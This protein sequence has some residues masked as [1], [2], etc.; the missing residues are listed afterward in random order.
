[1]LVLGA[2]FLSMPGEKSI[3]YP[4]ESTSALLER[5]C[6]IFCGDIYETA[7]NLFP[8]FYYP[9]NTIFYY[10]TQLDFIE[11]AYDPNGNLAI[12]IGL[13]PGTINEVMRSRISERFSLDINNVHFNESLLPFYL[14]HEIGHS[15]QCDPSFETFFGRLKNN[16]ID[17]DLDYDSYINSDDEQNADYIAS[18]IVGNSSLGR[19]INHL[20]P[21][22]APFEWKKWAENHPVTSTIQ[23]K[24][25]LSQ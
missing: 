24:K 3:D 1:M 10:S 20:P 8:S 22:E 14:A 15:V 18:V 6:G 7:L 11:S 17:S 2:T 21:Q 19:V 13:K 5:H 9:R 25:S 23:L 12:W 16:Y 4:L